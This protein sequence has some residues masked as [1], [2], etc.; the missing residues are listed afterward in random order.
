MWKKF[1]KLLE[2]GD[3]D[4]AVEALK[5]FEAAMYESCVE[6]HTGMIEDTYEATKARKLFARF[7]DTVAGHKESANP[8]ALRNVAFNLDPNMGARGGVARS[9]NR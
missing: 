1:M 4:L 7:A 3:V 8:N 6:L 2:N 9:Y 5:L